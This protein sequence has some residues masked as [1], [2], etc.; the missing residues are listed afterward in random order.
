M[1]RRRHKRLSYEIAREAIIACQGDAEAALAY[2][3]AHPRLYAINPQLLVLMIQIA[4][5]L[6]NYW[7]DRSISEPSV[8][9]SSEVAEILGESFFSEEPDDE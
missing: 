5:M 2:F 9:A 4:I 6:W 8:V 1:L 3:R 7:R